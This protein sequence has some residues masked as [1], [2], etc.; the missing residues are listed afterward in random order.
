MVLCQ[1]LDRF[2]VRTRLRE[3]RQVRVSE[4]VKV[5]YSFIGFERHTSTL[6]VLPDHCSGSVLPRPR[7]DYL[8]LVKRLE[9]R[10]NAL[11]EIPMQGQHIFAATLRIPGLDSHRRRLRREVETSRAK[12]LEFTLA[13]AGEHR[14]E[15]EHCAIPSCKSTEGRRVGGSGDETRNLLAREGPSYSPS[16]RPR[17]HTCEVRKRMVRAPL[18]PLEPAG[19]ALDRRLIVV[20]RLRGDVVLRGPTP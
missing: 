10:L 17:I 1:L 4:G 13:N 6:E 19:E 9:P 20:A 18:R 5:R 16:V 7:P 12:A 8:T 3:I 15:V 14:D 11:G 2:G